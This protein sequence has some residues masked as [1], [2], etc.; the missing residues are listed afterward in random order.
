[1]SENATRS[2][3]STANVNQ[4]QDSEP[5]DLDVVCDCRH[6]SGAAV[7]ASAT[8]RIVIMLALTTIV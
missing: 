4:D 1:M 5:Q 7:R 2:I 8:E 6:T 3:P